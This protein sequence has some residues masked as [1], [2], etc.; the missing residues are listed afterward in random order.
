[1]TFNGV[2]STEL[3]NGA[4]E[5]VEQDQTARMCRLMLLFTLRDVNPCSRATR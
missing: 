5:S 3:N 4:V 2:S 1:M